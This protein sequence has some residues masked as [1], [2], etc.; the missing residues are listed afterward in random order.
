MEPR[1]LTLT[2]PRTNPWPLLRGWLFLALGIAGFNRAEAAACIDGRATVRDE[3]ST[4]AFVA[5]VKP[6]AIKENVERIETYRGRSYTVQGSLQT[7]TPISSFKG[8]PPRTITLFDRYDSAS[9]PMEIGHRYLTFLHRRH[10]GVLFIDTCGNSRELNGHDSDL[11]RQVRGLSSRVA[12]APA[13][14]SRRRR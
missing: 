10:S 13:R 2:N 3:F 5:I 1:R 7:F 6:T 11:L 4:S 9:F 12:T 14:S 8:F